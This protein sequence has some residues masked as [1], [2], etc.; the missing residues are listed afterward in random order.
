MQDRLLPLST[1]ELC[2]NLL[3]ETDYV[4]DECYSNLGV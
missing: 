3:K 4:I 1:V 2:Y